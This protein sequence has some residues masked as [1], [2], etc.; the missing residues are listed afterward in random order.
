M[1]A[2]ACLGH[3]VLNLQGYARLL[4]VRAP[5]APL[6]QQVLFDFI[7]RQRAM[8]VGSSRD[9]GILQGLGVEACHLVRKRAD[10][11]PAP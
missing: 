11:A 3:E 5:V 1:T 2:T 4:A 7:A 8:L 9:F 6:E 10:R